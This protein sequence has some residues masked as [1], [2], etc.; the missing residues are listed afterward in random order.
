MSTETGGTPR[1]AKV[2]AALGRASWRKD[3]EHTATAGML[4]G[5]GGSQTAALESL[6]GQLSA[7]ASRAGEDPALWWDAD[8]RTLWI[9][10]PDAVSGDHSALTVR[11][12]GDVPRIC[13]TSSGTGPACK[14][15]STAVGMVPVTR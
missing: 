13:S 14:A 6:A 4:Q 8:N 3:S 12:D 10:V 15:F 5:R 11:M 7:M 2:R 9:A 1:Y